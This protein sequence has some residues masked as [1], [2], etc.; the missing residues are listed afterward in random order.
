MS[1]ARVRRVPGFLCVF[2]SVY[3]ALI[4]GPV[5]GEEQCRSPGLAIPDNNIA[6]VTDSITVFQNGGIASINVRLNIA[7][8]WVG[9]LVVTLTHV[10]TGVSAVILDR[11]GVPAL[12]VNGCSG[13]NIDVVLSDFATSFAEDDC[14]GGP[15]VIDGNA[16]PNNPLSV[17]LNEFPGG[18]WEINVR[19]ADAGIVG[20]LTSW[21]LQ[22]TTSI[23][24]PDAASYYCIDSS[25]PISPP[26]V[27]LF[28]DISASGTKVVQGTSNSSI[29]SVLNAPVPLATPFTFYGVT[30]NEL[31]MTTEGYLSTSPMD[32]GA[33]SSNDCG[34]PA[35]PSS[36]GGARIY[37]LHDNL[38]LNV[39]GG[40]YQYFPVCP[41]ASENGD[42]GGC[43]IFMWDNAD[44]FGGAVES[45]DFEALLYDNGDIVFQYGSGN[46]EFGEGST[47]GIQNDGAT[48][49]L[50]YACNELGTIDGPMAIRFFQDHD[51]DLISDG[52]DHCPMIFN[53][54]NLDTDGDGLGD[55]CDN[56]QVVANSGQE[57]ADGDAPGDACD[58]FAN[59]FGNDSFGHRHIDSNQPHGPTF[60]FIDIAATGTNIPFSDDTRHGPFALGFS[61]S[62]YGV[63]FSDC[64]ISSN[65]WLRLG[66]DDPLTNDLSN[67]CIL[68]RAGSAGANNFVASYWDD[69]DN[70]GPGIVTPGTGYFQ[71]FPAGS[72]P[73]N[74][75]PGACFIAE[76]LR[77]YHFPAETSM[78]SVTCEIVLLDNGEMLVQ[79]LDVS[80]ENGSGSTTGIEN[81]ARTDGLSYDPDGMGALMCNASGHIT[82]NQAIIFFDDA[83]DFDG[84]PASLDNCD[85]AANPNQEDADGDGIGDACDNAPNVANADQADADGD[86]V[87]DVIDVCPGSSDLA[88]T[89]NNGIPDCVE[90]G[91]GLPA[92]CCAPG[93]APMVGFF[94]PLVLIGWKLR[95]RYR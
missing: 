86:G 41:R 87:P 75:Y 40:Y 93:V 42:G 90:T 39:S 49:G 70:T 46:P 64:W 84:I 37:A 74:N 56:C 12:G 53:S 21:C 17:F 88:D 94:A 24:G 28:I 20:T 72:C 69:L 63:N 85:N 16:R 66:A 43:H 76:W 31:V 45:F 32:T 6:G 7:H 18:T 77:M 4:T 83:P 47:T 68:P 23:K 54:A 59:Q 89:N 95:R 73:Y 26:V 3:C 78:G 55:A 52:A 50:A 34:L 1:S 44:H 51:G 5:L 65:G 91:A 2:T 14:S 22:I 92:G 61:F 30:Y 19:D 58:P 27:P 36:G 81:M 79:F 11:P 13:D 60:N 35:P 33:D 80:D 25:V 8:T 9:D 82:D 71:A 38:N 15:P 48:I 10:D 57:N 67:D 29:N 62:F